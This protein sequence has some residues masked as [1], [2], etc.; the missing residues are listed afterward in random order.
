MS[1]VTAYLLAARRAHELLQHHAVAARWGEPSALAGFSIG[2]LAEHLGSQIFTVARLMA[3][4]SSTHDRIPLAEHYARATWVGASL[5]EEANTRIRDT[6]EEAA[7]EG[8]GPFLARLTETMAELEQTLPALAA[9]HLFRPPAGPW[10]LSRDDFL[11]TRMMELVVHSDDLA[12]SL[13]QPTPEFPDEVTESVL[14]L[15]VGIAVRRRGFPAVLRG[16]ARTERAPDTIS[17]F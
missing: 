17:A 10:A 6:G 16:L 7:A 11:L 12:Y 14:G 9:D 8:A 5:E 15:L 4:P 2:G 3:S 1:R 13:G